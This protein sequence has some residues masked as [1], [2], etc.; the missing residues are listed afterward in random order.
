MKSGPI[1][2][3]SG[4]FHLNARVPA[5][6]A[7][8]ARG[9]HITL[10]VGKKSTT[11]KIGDKVIV[12]LRTRD[13]DLAKMRFTEAAA[14]LQRYWATL[15][16]G[17]RSLSHRQIVALAGDAYRRRSWQL[18]CQFDPNHFEAKRHEI[19]Q[20]PIARQPEDHH[21]RHRCLL[22]IASLLEAFQYPT[23][24][25]L[26]AGRA[27]FDG[28]SS[29]ATG[30]PAEVMECLFGRDVDILCAE[31]HLAID[32]LTREK[33][34]H[35]IARVMPLLM[36][37]LSRHANGDYSP[38]ANLARFPTFDLLP[39]GPS[40]SVDQEPKVTIDVLFA[41]WCAYNGDKRAAST[42][43]RYRP[44]VARPC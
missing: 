21:D 17:P 24:R 44:S 15:R 23:P 1:A 12:S 42:I 27:L 40:E 4:I 30:S 18:E 13:V 16:T 43:R 26:R 9:N 31:R 29:H 25:R 35:E 39:I 6:L 19:Q 5:D 41:R 20:L 10:P 36:A 7:A 37:K 28:W 3:A 38:D 33:L 32:A 8:K 11:V 34:L 14:A 2:L 22:E